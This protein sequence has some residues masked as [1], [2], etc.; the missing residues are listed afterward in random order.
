[1]GFSCIFV[2]NSLLVLLQMT[3]N[4]METPDLKAC[5]SALLC[6]S[7]FLTLRNKFGILNRNIKL[8]KQLLSG[9]TKDNVCARMRNAQAARCPESSLQGVAA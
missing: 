6:V 8:T 5:S 9:S 7:T 4:Q 1:M 2:Y 3:S